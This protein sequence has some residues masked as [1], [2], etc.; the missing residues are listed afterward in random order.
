MAQA[1]T[2]EAYLKHLRHGGGGGP[3]ESAVAPILKKWA[4]S[5]VSDRLEVFNK[6]AILPPK[7]FNE[8]NYLKEKFYR[9]ADSESVAC[10]IIRD[11]STFLNFPGLKSLKRF[12]PN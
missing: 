7:L 3:E 11:R 5:I 2:Y 1:I 4:R 10:D 12:L 8:N 6:L 9:I